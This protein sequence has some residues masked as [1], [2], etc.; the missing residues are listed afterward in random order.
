MAKYSTKCERCGR[1]MTVELFGKMEYRRYRLENWTWI[2]E[3]CKAKEREEENR[4]AAEANASN[5]LPNLN[6]SPKQIAWAETIRAKLVKELD[7]LS[8]KIVTKWE[9][10]DK[11]TPKEEETKNKSL[12][13]IETLKN[14]TSAHKWIDRRNSSAIE[15]L[16]EEL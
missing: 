8:Q 5:G 2:C 9:A 11:K 14:E 13:I 1:E 4:R 7:E 3:E 10:Y 15:L 16:R 6:G 12:E